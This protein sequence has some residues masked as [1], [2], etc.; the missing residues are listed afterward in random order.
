MTNKILRNFVQPLLTDNGIM[1]GLAFACDQETYFTETSGSEQKGYMVFDGKLTG[2]EWQINRVD[3]NHY[4]WLDFYNPYPLIV[5]KLTVLN[6]NGN[7]SVGDYK[8]CGSND[9]ITWADLKTGTNENHTSQSRWEIS[10]N[11]SPTVSSTGYKYYRFYCKP[12]STTSMMIRELFIDAVYVENVKT[13]DNFRQVGYAQ[14]TEVAVITLLTMIVGET[15][16]RICDTPIEKFTDLGE[17]IYGLISNGNQYLFLPFSITLP[18]DDKTG[19]VSAKLEIDNVN[20]EIVQYA[21][22]TSDPIN[23]GIQVVLSNALNTPE[24][25]F[26]DF[27]L[28]N[29]KYNGFTISG[30]LSVDYLGLEP[31][32]AGRFT[33]SGFPGLF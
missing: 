8:V 20:R 33:P 24:L 22:S 15:T 29:V 26:N 28:T 18:Q 4:Y 30:N 7:Y 12:I 11:E 17:N 25:E 3:L 6:S 14:E 10:L 2:D 21:R 9:R 5:K 32:P 23:V 27:K 16:I 19:V 1:G 31:F 13:S